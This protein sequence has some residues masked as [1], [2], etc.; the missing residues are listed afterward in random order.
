MTEAEETIKILDKLSWDDRDGKYTF[1]GKP[2]WY[3]PAGPTVKGCHVIQDG[4]KFYF[5]HYAIR[6]FK[7]PRY[8]GFQLLE[9]MAE[10]SPGLVAKLAEPMR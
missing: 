8:G 3:I 2:A 5:R 1:D 10:E 4:N 6:P 7:A 9:A